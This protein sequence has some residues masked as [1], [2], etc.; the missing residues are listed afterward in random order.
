MRKVL[1]FIKDYWITGCIY[2]AMFFGYKYIADNQLF[3]GYLFPAVSK[4][5]NSFK[6]NW[7]IIYEY[8]LFI[9]INDSSYYYCCCNCDSWW[10]YSWDE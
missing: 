8:V 10:D 4:V 5:A 7:Y 3:G 2:L 6:E 9:S 1:K